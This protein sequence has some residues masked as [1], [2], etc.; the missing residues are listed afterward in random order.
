MT[1]RAF[2]GRMP[3]GTPVEAVTL[4]AGQAEARIIT[5]G[6]GLQSLFIPDRD[7]RTDDIVLGH[8]TLD[9]YLAH[10]K[11]FG[12]TVGRVANRIANGMFT[13]EGK[14]YRLPQNNGTNTLHGGPEGFD[15]KNWIITEVDAASVTL[16]LDS[17]SGDQGFPG[18]LSVQTRYV[19]ETSEQGHTLHIS[20]EGHT[21]APTPLA[22]TH[23]SYFALAGHSALADRPASALEYE[24]TVPAGHYLPTDAQQ[25]PIGAEPVGAT[26]F[27]FRSGRR[28]ATAIRAGA[29]DG[30][31]HCLCLDQGKAVLTDQHTGRRMTLKT[32]QLGL[33]VY[34]SNAFD[35]AI[36]GKA[37]RLYQKFDAICL[38]PQ[39]WPNAVNMPSDLCPCDVILRPDQIYRADI[40]LTFDCV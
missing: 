39:A 13:L 27:D 21:D 7:G 31:D 19:L 12:A 37:G 25:I 22:M 8:D 40:A 34:T 10:R 33:Q 16:S 23:H 28:C 18:A 4:R 1:E 29:L 35:G 30:Y 9:G 6:A 5:F 17:P 15:R 3:D 24:V 38:E 26:P 2:F 32:N 36:E 11:N 14:T 20:Y